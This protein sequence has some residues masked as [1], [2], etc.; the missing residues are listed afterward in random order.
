MRGSAAHW[1]RG[2]ATAGRLGVGAARDPVALVSRFGERVGPFEEAGVAE[3]GDQAGD[4]AS[5]CSQFVVVVGDRRLA[6]PT[7]QGED[8]LRPVGS[9]FRF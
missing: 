9:E 3:V 8:R 5:R 4:G 2:Q 1:L 7:G 6:E